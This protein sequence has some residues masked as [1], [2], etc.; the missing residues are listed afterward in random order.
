[1]IGFD[2]IR[3]SNGSYYFA[4]LLV[5]TGPLDR[6]GNY[7]YL[8]FS[9]LLKHPVMIYARNP[10]EFDF[11]YKHEVISFLETQNF[12]NPLT[13]AYNMVAFLDYRD[14]PRSYGSASI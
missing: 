10:E 4:V 12:L 7:D 11:F 5:K 3:M 13:K 8:I 2:Y 6:H 9:Q 14:C 1:M